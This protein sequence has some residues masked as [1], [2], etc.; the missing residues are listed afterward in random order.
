MVGSIGVATIC[1]IKGASDKL[2]KRYDY[3]DMSTTTKVIGKVYLPIRT[4]GKSLKVW[5]IGWQFGTGITDE[6]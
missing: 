5:H 4:D 1:K 3:R 2:Y 6:V